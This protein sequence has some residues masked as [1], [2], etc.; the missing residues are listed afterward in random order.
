[1]DIKQVR[2]NKLESKFKVKGV[3]G[4][5]TVY[6]YPKGNERLNRLIEHYPGNYWIVNGVHGRKV[7]RGDSMKDSIANYCMMYNSQEKE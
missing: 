5:I 3:N 2:S 7:V 1:M 4:D 6:E